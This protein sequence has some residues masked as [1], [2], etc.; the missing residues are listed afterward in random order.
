MYKTIHWVVAATLGLFS[1]VL[2]A[3]GLGGV[4]VDSYLNQ[5]L[6]VRVE[7]ISQS[8]SE[9]DSISAGLASADDFELLGLSRSAITVPL[10]FELVRETDKPYIHITSDLKVNEPVVQVLVEVVWSIGR[11]LREYTLFLDPPTIASTAPPVAIRPALAP[12][13]ETIIE[14]EPPPALVQRSPEPEVQT[15]AEADPAVA[16]PETETPV[17][18]EPTVEDPAADEVEY[19]AVETE[20]SEEPAIDESSDQDTAVEEEPASEEPST[21][22]DSL[23]QQEPEQDE[24]TET[25]SDG[26]VYGPVARGET[27]WGIARDFSRD[28]GY[29][30]NQ[31]MLA[32]QRKNPDAFIRDNINSLKSGAILRLP[33]FSE[34]AELTSRQAMLEVMRQEEEARSGIR[35]VAPEYATPT[36]AD[37]GDYQ[38][39]DTD[40]VLESEPE[41]DTG[42]LELVPPA[43][44][45][46]AGLAEQGVADQSIQE[47]L[48]RTEE[49]LINAQ[50]ENTYLTERLLE[51]EDDVNTQQ[52][53]SI[54]VEDSTLADLES[55][56]AE[57]RV[58]EEPE[59]PVAITPGGESQPWYA[60][61]AILIGV[62]IIIA[63]ILIIWVLRRRS[64]ARFDKEY[65]QT[66][67]EHD[68]EQQTEDHP[69]MGGGEDDSE[70][71]L[72]TLDTEEILQS[73]KIEEGEDD[74]EATDGEPEPGQGEK[75]QVMSSPMQ[76]AEPEPGPV[77]DSPPGEDDYEVKLDLARAYMSLGDQEASRSMLDDVVEN[78]NDAQVAEARQM[79][80]EL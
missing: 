35:T 5:P 31:T 40:V 21:E 22:D 60:G 76:E 78:G 63:I 53:E 42:H 8:S 52:E 30:I 17:S 7:L 25:L 69:T 3:L 72:R 65:A 79:L 19:Q 43:E 10:N 58:S 11:M 20:E 4:V 28:S 77:V 44:D 6:D 68:Q 67:E 55:A 34:L 24:F 29:S 51:M 15:P 36:V 32:L 13:E 1:P 23:E 2:L 80:D 73:I 56:L 74:E 37:S 12:V 38:D 9:L 16:E 75:T 26:K 46:D 70:A 59:A 39:S 27:L 61:Y 18:E 66:E 50:Q 57:E 41:V 47:E 49:E 54:A 62:G 33:A 45:V 48:S 14:D 64:A 71:V